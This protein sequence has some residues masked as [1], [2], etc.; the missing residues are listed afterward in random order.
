MSPQI[1]HKRAPNFS[2]DTRRTVFPLLERYER[3]KARR[4]RFDVMDLA[5]SIYRRLKVS[6]YPGTPIHE[7]FRDEVQDFT[8]AELLLDFRCARPAHMPCI[9][10]HHRVIPAS[11]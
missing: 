4:G 6:G 3:E 11:S 5:A 8:Q 9:R 10:Y 2:A 7:L 1:G